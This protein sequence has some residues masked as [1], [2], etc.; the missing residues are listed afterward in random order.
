MIETAMSNPTQ[1]FAVDGRGALVTGAANGLGQA[2][3]R[4]LARN[5]ARVLLVDNQP[6]AL[7]VAVSE[8]A[9]EGHQVRGLLADITNAAEMDEAMAAAAEWGSGLD[10]VCANAGVSAGLGAYFGTGALTQFDLERWQ[11]VLNVNLTGTMVTIRAAANH[12][13]E[14]NGRIIVTS[15]VAGLTT[16][17]LVGYAYSAS[18][19]AVTLFAQNVAAE[20]APRGINVNVIAPGSFLTSI[21][22]KNSGNQGM[23]DEL[24]RA[25][26]TKRLAD[27]SEIEGLA[28]LLAS[29]A[30][31]HITGSVFVIDGGVMLGTK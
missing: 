13:N 8:L 17:P 2:M 19:A 3:A 28:L 12:L 29:P 26:A 11:N 27:P 9:T 10:I 18:K 22:A 31:R 25:T 23:L 1:L 14:G 4:V 16:D 15:S 5:G 30:A 21:G 6:D 24:I 7:N 20:L